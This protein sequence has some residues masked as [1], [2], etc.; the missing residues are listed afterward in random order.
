MKSQISVESN[1]SF[2]GRNVL[3]NET[4]NDRSVHIGLDQE[5]VEQHKSS[6][7]FILGVELVN[8]LFHLLGVLYHLVVAVVHH[9][10]QIYLFD[11]RLRSTRGREFRTR[12]ELQGIIERT[13]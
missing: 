9:F 13:L 12:R 6:F 1:I 3:L 5:S 8:Q 7:L 11:S 10:K 2:K 4:E